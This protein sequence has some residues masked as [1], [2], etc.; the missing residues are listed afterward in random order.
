MLW[1]AG[2]KFLLFLIPVVGYA[3]MR[4][5]LIYRQQCFPD[6][7]YLYTLSPQEHRLF[8]KS[9]KQTIED[10]PDGQPFRITQY[11]ISYDGK[12]GLFQVDTDDEKEKASFGKM[13]TDKCA[14]LL[15]TFDVVTVFDKQKGGPV[16]VPVHR[17]LAKMPTDYYEVKVS[18]G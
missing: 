17:E 13:I 3:E 10:V 12:Y 14:V 7:K 6:D 5:Y 11:E 1:N 8:S 9:G 4:A 16:K 2:I 15:N 18:T